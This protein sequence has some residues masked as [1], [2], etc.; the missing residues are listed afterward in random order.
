[1][2]QKTPKPTLTGHRLKTRK[3]DEKEKYDPTGFRD[4]IIQGI[5]D[6]GQDLE[7]I[8]KFL[9]TSGSRLDYRRYAEVL[10][11]ILFAGGILAPG[12]SLIEDEKVTRCEVCVFL[13]DN[14]VEAVKAWEQVFNLLIRRYKYLEKAFEEELKKILLYLKGYTKDER[15]KL[16][17]ITGIFLA[18]GRATAN[19]LTSLYNEHLVKESLALEFITETFTVWFSE[20]DISNVATALRRAQLE[21]KLM[22]F[23]PPSKRTP[24]Y[25]GK[26]FNAAGLGKLVNYMEL[27]RTADSKKELVSEVSDMIENEQEVREIVS[28]CKE[29]MK[30]ESLEEHEVAVLLWKSLMDSVEWNKKEDLVAEQALRHLK[31]YS[32][33]LAEFT[34]QG[35]SELP[36]MLKIQEYCYDNMNFMKCFQ[37][38]IILFYKADVLSEDIIIKWYK[39]A[40]LAKGKSVFLQQMQKFVE[41]LQNAE[42]ES[43]EEDD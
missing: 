22:D 41:W 6:A 23:L 26:H 16:A 36:L 40:H 5:A 33:L 2:S 43:S 4:A 10:F 42:E 30:K 34:T 8:S 39:D 3:R 9:D 1:M 17:K 27:Q 20:K 21:N 37:K 35:K 18:N 38:I 15:S 31:T 24:E 14:T 11:D 28:Y 29:Q 19:V 25:F 13:A 12:G 32:P 7:Q